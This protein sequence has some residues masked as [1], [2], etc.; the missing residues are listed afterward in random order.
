MFD[1]RWLLVLCRVSADWSAAAGGAPADAAEAGAGAAGAALHVPQL[2][3]AVR[4]S[5]A[6]LGARVPQ[7]RLLASHSLTRS[8][9][10][11]LSLTH[12][13]VV[14]VE[15]SRALPSIFK[16]SAST[17]CLS[18]VAILF[19][20]LAYHCSLPHWCSLTCSASCYALHTYLIH[21][22]TYSYR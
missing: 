6:A 19:E 7:V 5:L 16:A 8:L 3:R 9:S 17:D 4:G 22:S 10:Q 11:S 1:T 14:Q 20:H 12:A 13:R 18:F 15:N 2:Q 21:N